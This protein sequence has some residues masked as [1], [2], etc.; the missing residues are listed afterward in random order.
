MNH[1]WIWIIGMGHEY[2]S[3]LWFGVMTHT[4]DHYICFLFI[5]MY[6]F[7]TVKNLVFS[8]LIA[9]SK[10]KQILFNIFSFLVKFRIFWYVHVCS[11]SPRITEIGNDPKN[12]FFAINRENNRIPKQKLEVPKTKPSAFIIYT[13][14]WS[15]T[16]Y[17][18][19]IILRSFEI[20]KLN[21]SKSRR[22]TDFEFR[23]I[24]FNFNV[25]S[26]DQKKFLVLNL[27]RKIKIYL[28]Y[29]PM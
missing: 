29:S 15:V 14:F 26:N 19:T 4:F 3:Y 20:S 11:S 18:V 6:L 12:W 9:K 17:D 22:L 2:D 25:L 5:V 10:S 28:W 8:R 16:S 1:V 13:Q 24:G 21:F 27:F 23:P 7:Y